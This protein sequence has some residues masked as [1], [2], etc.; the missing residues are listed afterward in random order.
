MLHLLV[1]T[2]GA[3]VIIGANFIPDRDPMNG[4]LYNHIPLEI[5]PTIYGFPFEILREYRINNPLADTIYSQLNPIGILINAVV[6]L[7]FILNV[8]VLQFRTSETKRN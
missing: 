1:C 3:S 7:L 2:I 5:D 4:L 8:L 6:V